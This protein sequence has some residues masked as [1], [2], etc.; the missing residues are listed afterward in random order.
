MTYLVNVAS[1]AGHSVPKLLVP[2]RAFRLAEERP[3][4]F[5]KAIVN[6]ARF[7]GPRLKPG[8]AYAISKNFVHWYSRYLAARFG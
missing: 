4:D 2:L 7:V 6:R 1:T 5:E 3:D 8:L